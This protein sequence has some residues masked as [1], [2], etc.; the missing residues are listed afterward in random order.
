MRVGID[1]GGTHTDAVLLDGDEV[2]A[3]VKVLTTEDVETGVVAALREL[4]A[5]HHDGVHAADA[6]VIGTTQFT[7][8]LVQGRGLAP[9]AILRLGLP[10]TA[11][12]H[13]FDDWP[14]EL[15]AAIGG[16]GYLLPGG[17][18]FDGREIAALSPPLLEKAVDELVA[19]G[20][21]A[22]AISSVFSPVEPAM[23]LAAAR[24]VAERAP[25]L[26]LTC[27]HRVGRLGLLERENAA[28]LNASLRP[29]AARV[30]GSFETAVRALRLEAPLYISQN[31][32][33][34]L[35]AATA[36]ELPVL[37]IA[38]GPT[39]SM[40]GAALLSGV[41][42]GL[43][44]DV[45]GTTSDFGALVRGYPREAPL[46]QQLSGVRT[47]FRMPDVLSLGLGGGSVV[48]E[49]GSSVGP[50]SV[51]AALV[52]RALA[53]GGDT[54][55]AS[56]LAISAGRAGFGNPHLVEGL[57]AELV[58]RGLGRIT[59]MLEEA[60]DSM[61]LVRGDVTLVAVGGGS[62]LVDEQLAGVAKVIRPA[63][64]EVAN[65]VGAACAGVSGQVDRI[66]RYGG[67]RAADVAAAAEE[68]RAAAVGA[69]ADPE[70]VEVVEIDEAPV[71]Y[72][73]QAMYR[74]RVK[75]VGPLARRS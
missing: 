64:H 22:V 68:A 73:E 52:E 49:E 50:A 27:S 14:D 7:N 63:H 29:L 20:T 26:E 21:A 47:S 41:L 61:K 67:D 36:R 58:A 5:Q 38:S 34:V 33:T 15:R 75:A 23:E 31:D 9:T 32:G 51:G 24:L 48:G 40:R 65:A 44:V 18:E 45:G 10:A 57:D 30:I 37:T 56:D 54:L 39:N 70:H 28:A 55:T 13:P 2:G 53:F 71:P 11:A 59:T 1:V 35:S 74:L 72:M 69:G 62:I 66:V 3:A 25:G 60:I 6:V 12:V 17:N 46:G 8:A 19:A 43:V 42:D 4:E 16:R